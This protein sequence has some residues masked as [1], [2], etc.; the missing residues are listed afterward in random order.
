MRIDRRNFLM[1]IAGTGA[2]ALSPRAMQPEEQ[3]SRATRG[4]PAPRIKDV[5]VIEC[6]PAGRSS[7]RGE[8]HHRSGRTLR[9]WMRHI[10]ATRRPREARS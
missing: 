7:H 3:V 9:L 6:A 2:L 8:D 10:H 1:T 4:M 5:S